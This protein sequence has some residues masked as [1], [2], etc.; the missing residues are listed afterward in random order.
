LELAI[1]VALWSLGALAATGI[2]A[3]IVIRRRLQWQRLPHTRAL[4]KGDGPSPAIQDDAL[5][6]FVDAWDKAGFPRSRQLIDHFKNLSIEWRFGD[7]FTDPR[8]KDS[9][10]ELLKMRGWTPNAK[11]I[12]VAIWKDATLGNTAFFHELTHVALWVIFNEPD[13]D[14]EGEKYAGW[15]AAHSAMI[16]ELKQDYSRKFGT[17]NFTSAGGAKWQGLRVVGDNDTAV[18]DVEGLPEGVMYC[19]SCVRDAES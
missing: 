1:V 10:G 8:V 19:G 15:S 5:L 7:Y 12:I 13:P 17:M 2:P 9:D 11:H 14:H 16:S 18:T 6:A 3:F 4:V